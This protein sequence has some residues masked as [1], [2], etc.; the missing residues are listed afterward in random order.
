MSSRS[1][2]DR[3][4]RTWGRAVTASLPRGSFGFLSLSMLAIL[5]VLTAWSS[6]KWRDHVGPGPQPAALR[7]CADPNNLPF[8]NEKKEG[9][10]NALATLV[11]REMGV[12]LEYYWWPQRR[13]FIRNTLNA[14][15]CDVTMGIAASVEMVLPTRPYYRS[16]YVFVSRRDRG[17]H[18]TSFDDPVLRT[19]RIGVQLIGDD[20]ANSPPV[21]ALAK[22]GIAGHAVGY[23]VY[24]DYEQPNP[25]A[26]IMDAV[27][28]GD[29]D[30]AIVWGP[31]AG[32]FAPRQPVPLDLVP[33]SPQ[34]DLPFMPFVFDIAM[35]VRRADTTL[36]AQLD[37]IIA[38][39]R[40]SIDSLLTAYG[41]PRP[42]MHIASVKGE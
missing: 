14:G 28:R 34:I 21:H 33:V 38:R 23:S 40:V 29:V 11:A 17:L 8:S 18:V 10:E 32:Y 37:D 1:S 6:S 2:K 36:R 12:P 3:G 30:L 19:L 20:F 13:G 15:T 27:A 35:G 5:L 41:V 39:R 9:F 7:V 31:L 16:T 26:R 22:R 42:G 25:P 4:P 24:G